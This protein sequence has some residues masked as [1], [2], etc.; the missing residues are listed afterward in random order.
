MDFAAELR[1]AANQVKPCIEEPQEVYARMIATFQQHSRMKSGM[2]KVPCAVVVSKSDAFGLDGEIR[3]TTPVAAPTSRLA[4]MISQ[5][6]EDPESAA[7]RQWLQEHG[8]GNL[9]RSIEKDFQQVRYFSCSALGRLPDSRLAPFTPHKALEPL[10][11]LL[12]R[13]SLRL[14]QKSRTGSRVPKAKAPR[15]AA[16]PTPIFAPKKYNQVLVFVLWVAGLL[17]LLWWS[18]QSLT[19]PYSLPLS[20]FSFGGGTAGVAP[21]PTPRPLNPVELTRVQGEVAGVISGWIE[22]LRNKNFGQYEGY[23]AND[24][25][26]AK[27]NGRRG[28]QGRLENKFSPFSQI[29]VQYDGL[30]VTPDPYGQTALAIF[31][32]HWKFEGAQCEDGAAEERVDLINVNGVWRIRADSASKRPI[33]DPAYQCPISDVGSEQ[34]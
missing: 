33:L 1:G 8:G 10:A 2:G 6:A 34:K 22:A 25:F 7:V 19:L 16:K 29:Y 28:F 14:T 13:Y 4:A 27:E 3:A 12:E 26:S 23:Y 18:T 15:S 5:K 20:W 17:G 9:V 30:Q 32:K 31:N 11:W 21:A 24:F